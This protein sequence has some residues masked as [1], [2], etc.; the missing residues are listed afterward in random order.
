MSLG[1]ELRWLG[2]VLGEVRDVDV[3]LAMIVDWRDSLEQEDRPA[4]EALEELL[5]ERRRRA[6][7][8][9]LRALDT[10]RYDRLVDRWTAALQREPGPR[11]AGS[12]IGGLAAAPQLIESR[13]LRVLKRGKK[14]RPSSPPQRYHTLRIRCKQ[15]RYALE[16]HEPLYGPPARR[17]IRA[18]VR[19]QDLLGDHQDCDVTLG[20]IR[21][22]T[23]DPGRRMPSATCFV[24]GRLAERTRRRAR[25]L[26][27]AF[28]ESFE[29]MEG[30]PWKRLQRAMRAAAPATSPEPPTP[31]PPAAGGAD[32]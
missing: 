5:T 16:F 6:R 10:R 20:W 28:P 24:L 27:R 1:K 26:R 19:L 7:R 15:L 2:R 30:K 29:P 31:R 13:Y 32:G 11:F 14:I 9:M 8:R 25:R 23:R 12:R 17:V 3:Q 18:L 4:L 21:D 22:L